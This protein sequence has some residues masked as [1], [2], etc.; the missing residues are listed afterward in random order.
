MDSQI[1]F[2][3]SGIYLLI[4]QRAEKRAEVE[5]QYKTVVKEEGNPKAVAMIAKYFE[6]CD[7]YWRGI[8]LIP[9]SGLKL[10]DEFGR[11]DAIK[12]FHPEVPFY[13]EPSACSCGDVLR[14]VKIPLDCPLFA[15]ACTPENPVGACMVSTEGSCAA[16]YKYGAHHG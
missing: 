14:G 3:P 11:F 9:G 13:P 7:A 10:R 1:F 16:Y 8:G 2:I 15:T 6:P 4:K 5:I 12:R